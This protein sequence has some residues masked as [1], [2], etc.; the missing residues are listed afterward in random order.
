[1]RKGSVLAH[2]VSRAG[3]S[4]LSH[5]EQ[6]ELQTKFALDLDGEVTENE[7]AAICTRSSVRGL[8]ETRRPGILTGIVN[9]LQPMKRRN[10]RS[11]QGC[12]WRNWRR[13]ILVRIVQ[14]ATHKIVWALEIMPMTSKRPSPR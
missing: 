11:C 14:A 2:E 8:D 5:L 3:D 6:G 12:G 4:I 7:E 13:P 9:V 1:M 10:Q